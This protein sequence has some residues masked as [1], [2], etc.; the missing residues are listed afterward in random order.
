MESYLDLVQD[1]T[2]SSMSYL[3][4]EEFYNQNKEVPPEKNIW[5]SYLKNREIIN[6]NEYARETNEFLLYTEHRFDS[7]NL[8]EKM[9]L[10]K[11]LP[12]HEIPN[13]ME[14][15]HVL[16]TLL[17]LNFVCAFGE[18]ESYVTT[19]DEEKA[20][21]I[22]SD[23]Y[24]FNPTDGLV[25]S[26]INFRTIARTGDLS[27]FADIHTMGDFIQQIQKMTWREY[28]RIT[29]FEVP[30]KIVKLFYEYE[31]QKHGPIKLTN[32]GTPLTIENI[33]YRVYSDISSDGLYYDFL[34]EDS[35][36]FFVIVSFQVLFTDENMLILNCI[37]D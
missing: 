6:P 30:Y 18:R 24:K 32:N 7:I 17:F 19:K 12:L 34:T 25:K 20:L 11:N 15:V 26:L 37:L 5:S 35:D 29:N 33:I 9:N 13:N 1:I 27:T 23:I 4:L 36:G 16:K 22:I 28:K 14:L 8:E 21:E 3:D 2:N 10:I 31:G